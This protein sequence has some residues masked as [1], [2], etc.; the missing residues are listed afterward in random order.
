MDGKLPSL[1]PLGHILRFIPERF[2]WCRVLFA[3]DSFFV[4]TNAHLDCTPET[5]KSTAYRQKKTGD[6]PGLFYPNVWCDLIGPPV[7]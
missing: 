6:D 4:T 2:S 3:I 7:S 1:N 5:D